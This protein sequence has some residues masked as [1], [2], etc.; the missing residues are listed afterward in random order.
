MHKVACTVGSR[1]G[2]IY[3]ALLLVENSI[4]FVQHL[5]NICSP[6]TQHISLL[7]ISNVDTYSIHF[8]WYVF[9]C[10]YQSLQNLPA[11]LTMLKCFSI[12][13][14]GLSNP[15]VCL[16]NIFVSTVIAFPSEVSTLWISPWEAVGSRSYQVPTSEKQCSILLSIWEESCC[17]VYYLL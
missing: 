9:C 4:C 2:L 8:I 13:I 17:W 14:I 1:E 7:L 16:Q 5:L 12:E 15:C 11:L 10:W 3:L 6:R